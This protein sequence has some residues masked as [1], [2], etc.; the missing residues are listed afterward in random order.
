M[1]ARCAICR[2]PLPPPPPRDASRAVA[3]PPICR[4]PGDLGAYLSL[5][6]GGH[7]F[8]RPPKMTRKQLVWLFPTFSLENWSSRPGKL[9]KK[10]HLHFSG[11]KWRNLGSTTA[12]FVLARPPSKRRTAA[13]PRSPLCL[14]SHARFQLLSGLKRKL[15]VASCQS[16]GGRECLAGQ[17]PRM[18]VCGGTVGCST[19]GK[20]SLSS[21]TN[22]RGTFS[23]E[24]CALLWGAAW[25]REAG[26]KC[27]G[28]THW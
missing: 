11:K 3:F 13:H 22:A 12:F 1:E 23:A 8:F 4:C 6:L 2:K 28:P 9:S 10:T 20:P 14:I 25:R 16:L 21:P 27:V 26:L 18:R 24:D 19:G 17:V 5:R 15:G 7:K